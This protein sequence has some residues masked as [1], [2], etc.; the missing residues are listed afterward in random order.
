MQRRH[1]GFTLIELLMVISIIAVLATLLFGGLGIV[2]ERSR[3]TQAKQTIDQLYAG[4]E[5]YRSEDSG[6][7]Y[8]TAASDDLIVRAPPGAAPT[9]FDLLDERR[10]IVLSRDQMSDG[11]LMDP[12][13]HPFRYSLSRPQPAVGG[14]RLKGIDEAGTGLE[15]MAAAWNWNP[16]PD[17]DGKPGDAS[18]SDPQQ[19]K[20]GRPRRYGVHW[21]DTTK[22]QMTGPLP[23]P[24]VWSLGKAGADSD[25]TH[26]IY[27][28]EAP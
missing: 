17:G 12:W 1:L 16:D 18:A 8:P 13:H 27:A 19:L 28:A 2:R 22:K 21:D 4:I 20:E 5:A 10:L 11:K 7:R 14:N 26:W 3:A 25:A 9:V 23:Y 24:Y 15:R 6:K